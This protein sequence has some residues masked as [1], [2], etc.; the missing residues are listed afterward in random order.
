MRGITSTTPALACLH[1][2]CQLGVKKQH[3]SCDLRRLSTD[4]RSA[5]NTDVLHAMSED[6]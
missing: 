3:A 5:L 1:T 2:S 4:S 6:V